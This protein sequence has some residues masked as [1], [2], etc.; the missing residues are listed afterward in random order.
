MLLI[1]RESNEEANITRNVPFYV[2]NQNGSIPLLN[3]FVNCHFQVAL[4]T[5]KKW[6]IRKNAIPCDSTASANLLQKKKNRCLQPFNKKIIA[7]ISAIQQRTR[8]KQEELNRLYGQMYSSYLFPAEILCIDVKH[9]VSK[10][11]QRFIAKEPKL[12]ASRK[13]DVTCLL[14]DDPPLDCALTMRCTVVMKVKF[15]AAKYKMQCYPTCLLHIIFWFSKQ[16]P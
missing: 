1:N 10:E 15:Y 3:S 13:R 2:L 11:I 5:S 16:H 14:K 6:K 9:T 7:S 8:F 4:V 12:S